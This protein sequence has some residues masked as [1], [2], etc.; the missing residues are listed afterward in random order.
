MR[1][2]QRQA[3]GE[4][5]GYL[6]VAQREMRALRRYSSGGWQVGMEG[7]KEEGNSMENV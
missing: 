5:A 4:G 2:W 3:E 7:E 6:M 1:G